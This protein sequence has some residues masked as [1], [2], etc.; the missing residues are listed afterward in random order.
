[1]SS[2]ISRSVLAILSCFIS[3]ASPLWAQH[4]IDQAA[5]VSAGI[6]PGSGRNTTLIGIGGRARKIGGEDEVLV[7]MG[8]E[9]SGQW[10]NKDNAGLWNYGVQA[11]F[12]AGAFSVQG[13]YGMGL[14]NA[15][16]DGSRKIG[17]TDRTR[18]YIFGAEVGTY[19]SDKESRKEL[20]VGVNAGL[21]RIRGSRKDTG[22]ADFRI[23][24]SVPTAGIS[25]NGHIGKPA[26]RGNISIQCTS[27]VLGNAG[28]NAHCEGDVNVTKYLQMGGGVRH[29]KLKDKEKNIGINSPFIRVTIG[30]F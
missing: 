29:V 17:E 3:M 28:W 20:V 12:G 24:K 23:S 22:S 27:A 19:L 5:G 1:M 11:Q 21:A 26:Q 14:F 25:L 2:F 15:D 7:R 6:S 8:A 18:I 16:F 30:H 9:G 13:V 4:T 10:G